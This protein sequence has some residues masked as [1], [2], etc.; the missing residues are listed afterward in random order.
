MPFSTCLSRR[1]P[2]G[3][4]EL[5]LPIPWNIANHRLTPPNSSIGDVLAEDP[6]AVGHILKVLFVEEMVYLLL[7]F[8]IKMSFLLFFLRLSPSTGFRQAV[9]AVIGLNVFVTVATWALYCL[10]CTPIEAFWHPE[11][12][13]GV[14]CLPFS[15]SLWL[16]ASA[17]SLS[18]PPVSFCT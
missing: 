11:L 9:F 1:A 10:Q 12:H 3:R 14:R 13:P 15:L 8:F 16:P 6:A 2:G 17:V 4:F 18:A 7:H 5:Q